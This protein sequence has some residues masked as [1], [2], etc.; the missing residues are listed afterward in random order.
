MS[1]ANDKRDLVHCRVCGRY[2]RGKRRVCPHDGAALVAVRAFDARPGDVID[3]RYE[4]RERL[5]AGGMGTVHQAWD[6]VAARS[7]ALKVLNADYVRDAHSARRFLHEARMLRR[8]NHQGVVRVHRFGRTREGMLVIDMEFLEGQTLRQ[9]V[10]RRRGAPDIDEA[11]GILDGVLAGLAACHDH[12]VVHC[13]VKP[14]NVMLGTGDH[15]GAVKLIDFGIAQEPGPLPRTADAAVIGT[16]AYMSPEQVQGLEVDARTDLYL[17]GC[18]VYELLTGDPPFTAES[19]VELCEQQVCDSPPVLADRIP[20]VELPEGFAAWLSP[21]LAKS[22]E[23]RPAS[24]RVVR[25]GLRTLRRAWRGSAEPIAARPR[26]RALQAE[27]PR[28]AQQPAATFRTMPGH[29]VAA[30]T[31]RGADGVAAS[32]IDAVERTAEVVRALVEIRQASEGQVLYGPRAIEEIG[33]HLLG[34]PLS[35]LREAGANVRGP[36]G[37]HIEI[38]MATGGDPRGVVCHLLDTLE[39]MDEALIRVPEPALELR[40]AV[41]ATKG[42]SA[43]GI[44]GS[45]L[46]ELLPLMQIGPMTQVRVDDQVARWAGRRSIAHLA[47]MRGAV[48]SEQVDIFAASLRVAT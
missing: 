17:F 11:L 2:Y 31:A 48:A 20:D 23:N 15:A 8:V 24:A 27:R 47:R 16:P 32:P 7:V 41:S 43:N 21:L 13:D 9:M 35:E 10:L 36:N 45:V 40:A 38:I 39:E 12:G 4:L 5:G 6:R 42:P 18:V 33:R 46:A 14:E 28:P 44:Y 19:P 30:G 22:P 1:T 25:D 3:D 34:A 29:G 26:S 37:P